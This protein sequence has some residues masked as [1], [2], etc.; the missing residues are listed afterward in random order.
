MERVDGIDVIVKVGGIEVRQSVDLC[1]RPDSPALWLRFTRPGLPPVR[2]SLKTADPQEA[3]RRAKMIIGRLYNEGR[4]FTPSGP[5]EKGKVTP[6]IKEFCNAFEDYYDRK[7]TA[8]AY[9]LA[10]LKVARLGGLD[11]VKAKLDK[12]DE[13]LVY[14]FLD[15]SQGGDYT[16]RTTILSARALFAN[17]HRRFW[18]RYAIPASIQSFRS[19]Q[20]PSRTLPQFYPLPE[21]VMHRIIEA[22]ETLPGALYR[23]H[24]LLRELGLR[25]HEAVAARVDWIEKTKHGYFFHLAEDE[26]FLGKNEAALRRLPIAADVAELL[27]KSKGTYIVDA[28]CDTDRKDLVVRKHAAWLRQFMPKTAAHARNRRH[29]NQ[30]LRRQ[31]VD[32]CITELHWDIKSTANYT[33]H[34]P[35]TL[36]DWYAG[37]RMIAPPSMLPPKKEAGP[38]VE[39]EDRP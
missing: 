2:K 22:A 39:S 10:L 20:I 38:R 34:D 24:L 13:G 33:R 17:K 19:A 37:G 11:P 23:A 26:W 21:S 18:L 35:K 31:F 8:K 3:K 30:A 27:L 36:L 25:S 9:T 4:E 28:D 1:R 12:L 7:T 5:G 29:P 32:R 15:A 16:K 6:T 14:R